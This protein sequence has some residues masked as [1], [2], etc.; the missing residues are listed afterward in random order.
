M[1]LL[2]LKTELLHPVDK[3]GRIRTYNMLR[4]LR[5]EHGVTYL[6]LD[7]GERAAD[8][9]ERSNE[10]C[11][12]LV[13][14]PFRSSA[15][16]SASFYAELVRSQAS[17]LPYAIWKYRSSEMR[18]AI[19]RIVR[20]EH[21][22]IVVCDFLAP[23]VNVPSGL[24]TLGCASVLFQHNVEA[25][26]W[27][28]H[29]TNASNILTARYMRSQW[30][31]MR[32]FE[33]E[34]CRRFDGVIAVSPE[35][36]MVFSEEYGARHVYDVPTG[37]DTDYFQPHP[38][39]SAER[40]KN[41]LVFTGSMDWLP[42]EDGLVHFVD[43]VFPRVKLAVPDVSL[44]IVGRNPSPRVLSLAQR[45]PAVT[46]TGRVADVRPYISQA[47]VF[48]VPLRVGGGTRLKIFEAM[49]MGKAVVST[50]IG[51]EGL[52]VTGGENILLADE[53]GTQADAI[54][55]LLRDPARAARLGRRAA[56]DVRTSFGWDRVADNFAA[57]CESVVRRRADRRE[58]GDRDEIS[59]SVADDLEGEGGR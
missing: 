44:A 51:A 15:K 7:D 56:T 59:Y 38:S 31:R 4:Y 32:D 43:A 3:G 17:S 54:V 57:I 13:C 12:R 23:A 8:A 41:G 34:Q 10:Y 18:Q 30:K 25:K 42:N 22:D 26:I 53:P 20:E 21:I 33:A 29:A 19:E 49:A 28:R 37:V 46:V 50:T 16:R 47:A 45:D 6:A 2:W 1:H 27:E 40:V 55:E 48:V 58:N 11:H 35:D 5:R 39:S 36:R 24:G 52:P 14:L 9:V